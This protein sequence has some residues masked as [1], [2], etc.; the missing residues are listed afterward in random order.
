MYCGVCGKLI[1]D[2]SRFCNTCGNPV[3]TQT[4]VNA[5]NY[6]TIIDPAANS[7]MR[8]ISE[9]NRMIEYY[10]PLQQKYDDLDVCK[11]N[12]AYYKNRRSYV[13]VKGVKSTAVFWVLGIVSFV[14]CDF[15]LML[16]Y[17]LCCVRTAFNH[18][19]FIPSVNCGTLSLTATVI[20]AFLGVF[21]IVTGSTKLRA[22]NRKIRDYRNSQISLYE[23]R[24]EEIAGELGEYFLA[25]GYCETGSEYTNPKILNALSRYIYSGRAIT[26]QEAINLLHLDAH[27][28]KMELE[29]ELIS[30]NTALAA[31]Y[32]RKA[33]F[34]SAASFFF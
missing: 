7:R 18:P 14:L 12:I 17:A 5:N 3:G 34:F 22:N 33:A 11:D 16:D 6:Q 15:L 2:G 4:I 24:Y 26:I 23:Q 21:L 19:S 27:N 28:S 29:A 30:M 1:G 20:F 9:I 31:H 13:V 8:A 10:S 25:Y 32:A